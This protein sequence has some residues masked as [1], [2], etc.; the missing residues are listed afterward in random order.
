MGVNCAKQDGVCS[1]ELSGSAIGKLGGGREAVLGFR[2]LGDDL[3]MMG[4][5]DHSQ[6]ME[7]LKMGRKMTMIY[8]NGYCHNYVTIILS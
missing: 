4:L 2:L 1:V 8:Y 3:S 5:A 6:I 7:P